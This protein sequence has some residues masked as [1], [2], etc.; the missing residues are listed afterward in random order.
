MTTSP[1]DRI[2]R[3]VYPAYNYTQENQKFK[4]C[5]KRQVLSLEKAND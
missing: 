4:Y 3:I 2:D 5:L 1:F